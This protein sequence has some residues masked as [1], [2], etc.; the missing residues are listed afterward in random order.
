MRRRQS[1]FIHTSSTIYS[2]K[3]KLER[4][5][6]IT[7]IRKQQ[8]LLQ[9]RMQKWANFHMTASQSTG[10]TFIHHQGKIRSLSYLH[11]A[12]FAYLITIYI[13]KRSY[14]S[15]PSVPTSPV[16]QLPRRSSENDL[17]IRPSRKRIKAT[18]GVFVEH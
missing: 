17:R 10:D 1:V 5:E 9:I 11:R 2:L 18:H 7:H 15:N 8:D 4:I 12:Y 13:Y 16:L 14:N 3:S 6:C